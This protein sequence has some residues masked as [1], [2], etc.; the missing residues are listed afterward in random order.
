[1]FE[2]NKIKEEGC[3]HGVKQGRKIFSKGNVATCTCTCGQAIS[4]PSKLISHWICY[5]YIHVHVHVLLYY[6]TWLSCWQTSSN[7]TLW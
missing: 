7:F 5:I 6:K 4:K 1:M 3:G 2:N